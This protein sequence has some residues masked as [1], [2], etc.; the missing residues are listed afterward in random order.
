[1]LFK[2][3][4]APED[5]GESS[6]IAIVFNGSPLLSGDPGSDPSNPPLA[7]AQ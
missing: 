2:R 6:R 4:P 5:G 1:M 7:R 3:H